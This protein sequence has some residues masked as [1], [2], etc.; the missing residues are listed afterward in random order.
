MSG[1]HGYSN[2]DMLS[3]V[4]KEVFIPYCHIDFVCVGC[5]VRFVVSGQ[6][7]NI[8]WCRGGFGV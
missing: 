7:V 4:P 1:Y 8:L 3:V 2:N 6:L 5:S